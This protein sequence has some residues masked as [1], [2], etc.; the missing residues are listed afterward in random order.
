MV[1][2]LVFITF[3]N[4]CILMYS[5]DYEKLQRLNFRGTSK[6]VKKLAGATCY[7]LNRLQV[8]REARHI[9]LHNRKWSVHSG[10]CVRSNFQIHMHTY[11]K[12]QNGAEVCE[13]GCTHSF[14]LMGFSCIVTPSSFLPSF[15]H[16]SCFS[17]SALTERSVFHCLIARAQTVLSCAISR[18]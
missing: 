7:I 12:L 4:Y 5:F 6:E 18:T 13:I 9:S 14:Y 1:N 17:S 15:S 2:I 8:F 16:F 11:N 10:L 3:E